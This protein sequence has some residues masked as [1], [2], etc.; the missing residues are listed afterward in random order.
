MFTLIAVGKLHKEEIASLRDAGTD[1]TVLDPRLHFVC[2]GLLKLSLFE[3]FW[4]QIRL[5]FLAFVVGF[6]LELG[7]IDDESFMEALSDGATLVED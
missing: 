2:L 7:G 3:A 1:V 4:W 6:G 5:F